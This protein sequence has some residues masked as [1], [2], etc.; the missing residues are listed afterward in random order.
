MSE[1]QLLRIIWEIRAC[2]LTILTINLVMF[3]I[4]IINLNK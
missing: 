4:L 3:F 2:G 1:D